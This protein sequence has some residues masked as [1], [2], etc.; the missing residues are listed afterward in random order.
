M[1]VMAAGIAVPVARADQPTMTPINDSGTLDFPA[2]TACDFHYAV[3][4]TD[5]GSQ[6]VFSDRTELHIVEVVTHVN[7]DTGYT[8]TERDQFNVTV[9]PDG[10]FKQVGIVWHLRDASGKLVVEHSGQVIVDP[11]GNLVKITPGIGPDPATTICTALGGSP[12]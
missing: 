5:T 10:T 3:A 2:G 8:L 11:S 9:Y 12:A 7:V 6:T 4:F 1:L